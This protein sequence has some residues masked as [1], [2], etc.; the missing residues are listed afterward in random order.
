[1]DMYGVNGQC[2]AWPFIIF[3]FRPWNF[4]AAHGRYS[5]GERE[6]RRRGEAAVEGNRYAAR[7]ILVMQNWI[8]HRIE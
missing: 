8:G 3:P 4:Q 1:M 7:E 2:N 6:D 5:V